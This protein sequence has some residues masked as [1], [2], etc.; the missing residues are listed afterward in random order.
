M[1][2]WHILL[3]AWLALVLLRFAWFASK[4]LYLMSV[5]RA[6]LDYHLAIQEKRPSR[7]EGWLRKQRIIVQSLLFESGQYDDAPSPRDGG[8]ATKL[9]L[10]ALESLEHW[11]SE[12][13]RGMARTQEAMAKAIRIYLLRAARGLNPVFWVS[14]LLFFPQKVAARIGV[15]GDPEWSESLRLLYWTVLASA[16]VLFI[17]LFVRK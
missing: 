14:W 5:R 2:W 16:V 3:F 4:S 6:L 1:S 9:N 13:P 8:R 11:L 17:I 15:S 7:H 12:H 10:Y